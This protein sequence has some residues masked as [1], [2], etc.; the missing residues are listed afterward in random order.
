MKILLILLAFFSLSYA[1]ALK[2]F[3]EQKG[4][5]LLVRGYFSGGAPCVK[6]D[7]KLISG[8]A[9]FENFK[10]DEN[11][12]ASVKIARKEFE[13][14]ID[15]SLGHQKKINFAASGDF[16]ET[17]E[18]FSGEKDDETLP[19]AIKF[20]LGLLGIFAI[21]SALYLVKRR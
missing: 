20:I 21:F 15:G 4:E 14:L 12:E 7:V 16:A 19:Y 3:A 13:I 17:G 1:H 11:G 6:C 18:N 2:I 10:T 9:V 5:N 8:G